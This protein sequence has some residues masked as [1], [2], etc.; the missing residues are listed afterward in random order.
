MARIPYA[1]PS[2]FDEATAKL[3]ERL[4]PLNL[5]KM[6]AHAP[7]LLRPFVDLGG[8][9]L[10]EG[11]LDPITRECAIL[12]V[13]YVSRAMYE[14]SQHEKI[15]REL[16][17]SDALFDAIKAGPSDPSLSEEQRLTL[18]LVDDL[19]ANVKAGDATF[20]LALAHFGVEM[21]QELTLVTG[22][23]MMVCRFLETFEID[24]EE[25]GAQGL[26]LANAD[27]LKDQAGT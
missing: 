16:G 7:G 10:F 23:Y 20:Q 11:K 3:I 2:Q 6:L 4:A 15:G 25:G 26:N 8:A 27:A 24:L 14:T 18:A 12:R 22:Y 5:F 9:F 19:M 21:T 17:M 1:D 13:G